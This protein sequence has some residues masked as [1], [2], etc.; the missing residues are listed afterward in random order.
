MVP[1]TAG[2]LP[3]VPTS[4]TKI[5]DDAT[6]ARNNLKQ[7]IETSRV[8]LEYALDLARQSDSPR[9]YEVLATMINTASDLNT[10]LIDVHQ[11]EQKM[12]VPGSPDAPLPT[13]QNI[14]NN[15]VFA[16]TT[17]ELNSLIMKQL[18]KS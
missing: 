14:T 17:A 10:K 6:Y 5:T 18:G 3:E 8:A 4:T 2:K 9:A 15:V 7:L 1:A 13:A 16:G 12:T 11:R